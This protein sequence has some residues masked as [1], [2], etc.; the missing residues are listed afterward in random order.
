MKSM[1][2]AFPRPASSY[3]YSSTNTLPDG[4]DPHNAQDGMTLRDYFAAK[5]LQVMLAGMTRDEFSD[6]TYKNTASMA[7][8][9]ADAMLAER[10]KN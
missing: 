7:Y 5:T 2:P 8:A 6:V 1:T 9:Q 3:N 4:N 10:A